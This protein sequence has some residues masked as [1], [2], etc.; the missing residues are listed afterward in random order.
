MQTEL[1][2]LAKQSLMILG[3][4]SSLQRAQSER[5]SIKI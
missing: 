1:V 3:T 5:L 4:F 2:L